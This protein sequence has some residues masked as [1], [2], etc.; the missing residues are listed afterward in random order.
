M[1]NKRTRLIS[2]WRQVTA[3]KADLSGKKH[4]S[5]PAP[6]LKTPPPATVGEKVAGERWDSEGGHAA[7][8]TPRK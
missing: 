3:T 4:S 1:E 5:G 8:T 2:G 7:T 6:T